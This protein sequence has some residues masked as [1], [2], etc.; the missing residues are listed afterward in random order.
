MDEFTVLSV[1]I[2]IV[3][4]PLW[5]FVWKKVIGFKWFSDIPRLKIAFYGG[6]F[7]IGVNAI[8]AVIAEVPEYSVE[9]GIYAYVERNAIT[10]AGLSLAIATFIIVT[11]SRV[12]TVEQDE[13]MHLF[14]TSIF[15]AFLLGILGVLPL[16]WVPQVYGWLTLLRHLKTL[17]ELYSVFILGSAMIIYID[18]IRVRDLRDL[19]FELT[20]RE[21]AEDYKRTKGDWDDTLSVGVT[22]IDEQHMMLLHR[23]NQ[24]C[25]AM[26]KDAGT[27]V[28]SK[29]LT[30]L[31]EYVEHH[32]ETEEKYMAELEYSDSESHIDEHE[33]FK[34]TVKSFA[35]SMLDEGASD[36]LAER[37]NVFLV[38]WLLDHIQETDSKLG[39]FIV[40]EQS[41]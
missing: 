22:E 11:F 12:T 4:L 34:K 28:L 41:S 31:I 3:G 19:S 5:A 7:A 16:Y 21:R 17:P 1:L 10:V 6:V 38:N 29:T 25:E 39:L 2:Y 26:E 27:T 33:E 23:V 37:V 13:K 24:L 8:L 40:G 18:S 32:F 30:F 15:T 9:A 36:E 35:Q 20:R 14:L